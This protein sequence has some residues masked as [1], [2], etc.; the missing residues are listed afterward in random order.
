MSILVKIA[1][2]MEEYVEKYTFLNESARDGKNGNF[3][4]CGYHYWLKPWANSN[5]SLP[6]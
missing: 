1:T 2:T 4:L 6:I 5:I 3:V